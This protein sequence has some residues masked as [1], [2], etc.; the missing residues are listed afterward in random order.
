VWWLVHKQEGT[1]CRTYIFGVLHLIQQ[2]LCLV[3]GHAVGEADCSV[4]WDVGVGRIVQVEDGGVGNGAVV[5][6]CG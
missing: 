2:H 1:G 4:L 5:S 6:N 3:P